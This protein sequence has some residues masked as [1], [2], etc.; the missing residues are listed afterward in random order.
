MTDQSGSDQ[1]ETMNDKTTKTQKTQVREKQELTPETLSGIVNLITR[2]ADKYLDYSDRK[3]NAKERRLNLISKHNRN[4]TIVLVSSLVVIIGI[5]SLLTF[6][7][8]VSGDALLFL[9]G[10]LT[11]YVLFMIQNLVLPMYEESDESG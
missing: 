5:M 9:V 11:G 8:K 10:T 7:G 1:I 2:L 3:D 6:L 4:L